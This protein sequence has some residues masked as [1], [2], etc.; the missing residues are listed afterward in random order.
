MYKNNNSIKTCELLA[1]QLIEEQAEALKHEAIVKDIKKA[2]MNKKMAVVSNLVEGKVFQFDNKRVIVLDV[3]YH[4]SG[5]CF[6]V[7]I[8]FGEIPSSATTGLK[9]TKKE[10]EVIECY[11]YALDHCSRH[12]EKDWYLLAADYANYL[13]KLKNGI[14]LISHS[15]Y[16]FDFD[17]AIEP[18]FFKKTGI[19]INQFQGCSNKKV[20]LEE[21][22][23]RRV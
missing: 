1:Q 20:L 21:T 16:R 19:T 9:L 12:F 6:Y 14:K 10:S 22:I 23:Y 4:E 2:I 5:N 3:N 15:L 13:A 17:E 18:D 8:T 11:A 7:G